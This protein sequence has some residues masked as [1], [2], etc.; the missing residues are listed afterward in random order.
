MWRLIDNRSVGDPALNLA[1]EEYILRNEQFTDDYLLI[2]RNRSSVIIGRNQNVAQEANLKYCALKNIP[3]C[4]RL[5]GGGAVYHDA[6]NINF[7]FITRRSLKKVNRYGFFIEPLLHTLRG[8]G[9]P[10]RLDARSN[11]VLNG[12]KVSGNAQFTSR[13]R[14]LS[15]GTLLFNTNLDALRHSLHVA[16]HVKI[17]SRS[18]PSVRGKVGNVE[19]MLP[20]KLS[21]SAFIDKVIKAYNARPFQTGREAFREVMRL[22]E[23]KYAHPQWTFGRSPDSI[24]QCP[25]GTGNGTRRIV[26]TLKQGHIVSVDFPDNKQTGPEEREARRTLVGIRFDY[27]SLLKHRI[28]WLA[29]QGWPDILFEQTEESS[30]CKK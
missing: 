10:A 7:S 27:L 28:S 12:L 20:L 11:I 24:L 23:T 15:H 1:W 17:I 8:L 13:T 25:L 4:R 18:S 3:V 5:S 9:V 16:E 29:E 30:T 2:Y 26:L 14:M 6:G 19:D 22:A 21:A